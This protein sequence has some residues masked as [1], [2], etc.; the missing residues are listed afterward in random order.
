ML[1]I[2]W[3]LCARYKDEVRHIVQHFSQLYLSQFAVVHMNNSF[4]AG[5]AAEVANELKT[6]NLQLAAI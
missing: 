3:Y 4:G 5:L 6:R 1:A 2:R